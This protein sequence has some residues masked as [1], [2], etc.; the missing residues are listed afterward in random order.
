[1]WLVLMLAVSAA[2]GT[3]FPRLS[4]KHVDTHMVAVRVRDRN[5]TVIAK[6]NGFKYHRPI[7]SETHGYHLLVRD[8][9][10]RTDPH[11]LEADDRVEWWETQEPKLRVKRL[12]GFSDPLYQEQ[13]HLNSQASRGHTRFAGDPVNIN[14]AWAWS[15]GF[16]G[17]GVVIGVVD[18]GLERDHPDLSGSY[19][20]GL[21]YDWNDDDS[22]P[23]PSRR[24]SHGTSAS[25]VAG[26]DADTTCGVGVAYGAGLAGQ[27]LLGDWATDAEEAQA[28]SNHCEEDRFGTIHVFSNSWGP[29]DDGTRL[30]GPGLITQDAM[31]RCIEHGRGGK[32]TIYVWAGGNGRARLDNANYDGYANSPYT[33]AVAATND[34]GH[35]TW[36]SEPGANIL[37]TAPSSGDSYRS[38]VTT[39]LKG[40][41]G[42]NPH[43][44]CTTEFGGTSATC[45]QVAGVVA[46]MLQANPRLGWKD[47]QY[48]L[49]E[50]SSGVDPVQGKWVQNTAGYMHSYSYGFGMV[51]A[52]AAV[53][54]SMDWTPV[55]PMSSVST[56]YMAGVS[57]GYQQATEL[58][59]DPAQYGQLQLALEH[60]QLY[61]Q[62]NT[63]KGHG[64]LGLQLCGPLGTCSIMAEGHAPGR[65]IMVDWTYMTVRNWGERIAYPREQDEARVWTLRVANF[66]DRR[67]APIEVL[68][69]KLTF[70]GSAPREGQN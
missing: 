11:G 4:R 39:D 41:H 36:Y 61:V 45:P 47:V 13:W 64:H 35:F 38:I 25:G 27:R 50:T 5:V 21:S 49:A 28:L 51:N 2:W 3:E 10:K 32:G 67:S 6:E 56:Q 29:T 19:K 62:A 33:I 53:Q 37:C 40:S 18:D 23:T 44:D 57:V 43:G 65:N 8:G 58:H 30:D 26:A 20:S 70:H 55:V 60:V 42:A 24:D 1:M 63:P 59:W 46:M 34:Y 22:D 15:R 9:T 31:E 48:I 16:D 54:R 52:S 14:T 68:R 7:L 17:R 66:Y 12:R 69:W